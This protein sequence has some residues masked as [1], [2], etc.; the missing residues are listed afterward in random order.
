MSKPDKIS[1]SVSVN[2]RTYGLVV[3]LASWFTAN[4]LTH[5]IVA[6][7]T[8]GIYYQLPL[9]GMLGA[10]A[11]IAFLNFIIPLIALRL[12]LKEKV[13]FSGTL[14]WRW[15]GW[16]VPVFAVGGFIVFMLLSMVTNWLF[17]NQSIQYGGPGMAGPR[18]ATDY[19]IFTLMLL[20]FPALG[21]ET[22][23]RGF[24]Q[25]R[26]TAT[27]GP[28]TGILVPAVLFAVRHHPS[29]IYFGILNHVPL[30]GWLNRGIQLYLGA[31]IFGLVRHYARS[32][33]ASWLFHMMIILMILILGGF[34]RGI[35]SG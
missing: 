30:A 35:V 8:G 28:A 21:E 22:M 17:A 11:S 7:A 12:F 16:R 34:F 15:T 31:I 19:L 14:G 2:N 13:S 10:E 6:L 3:L 26:L 25:T 32:T 20:I 1:G 24:L 29:D 4:A 5:V 23:F 18:S 33:W 27:Y 9:Y